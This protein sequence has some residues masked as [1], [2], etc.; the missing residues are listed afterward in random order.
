MQF[1]YSMLVFLCSTVLFAQHEEQVG[2]AVF[3]LSLQA[4][5]QSNQTI[6]QGVALLRFSASIS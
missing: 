5:H 4:G 1:S 2:S 3:E 6:P